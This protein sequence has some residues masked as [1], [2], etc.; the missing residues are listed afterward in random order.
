MGPA[1]KLTAFGG[2][3]LPQRSQPGLRPEPKLAVALFQGPANKMKLKKAS[4]LSIIV[5]SII[6]TIQGGC[7]E[8]IHE[9]TQ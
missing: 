8:R 2:T 5:W 1:L 3:F 7:H 4:T 6:L 9:E